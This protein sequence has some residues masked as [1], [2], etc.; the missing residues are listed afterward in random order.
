MG[1][2]CVTGSQREEDYK[3]LKPSSNCHDGVGDKRYVVAHDGNATNF[4]YYRSSEYSMDLYQ[5][6]DPTKFEASV[7]KAIANKGGF[8]NSPGKG[9][10][11][12]QILPLPVMILNVVMLLLTL[13]L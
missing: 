13:L 9:S 6:T 2:I 5:I 4:E 8:S 3:V 7:R 12:L 11:G 1:G 10:S